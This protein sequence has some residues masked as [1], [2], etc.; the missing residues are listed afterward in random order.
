MIVNIHKSRDVSELYNKIVKMLKEEGRYIDRVRDFKLLY[1][2]LI[3]NNEL[4]LR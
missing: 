4:S 2:G 3:V 1:K